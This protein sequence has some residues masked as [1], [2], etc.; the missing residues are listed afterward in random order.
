MAAVAIAVLSVAGTARVFCD[1]GRSE[2]PPGSRPSRPFSSSRSSAVS[3]RTRAF[4]GRPDHHLAAGWDGG[5]VRLFETRPSWPESRQIGPPSAGLASISSAGEVALILNCQLDWASVSARC[6]DANGRRRSTRSA[7]R[8]R[9]R[10]LDARRRELAAIQVAGGIIS[11]SSRSAG[12]STRRGQ[13]LT[14]WHSRLA[15]TGSPSSST[16]FISD[17]AGSLKIVDLEGRA[18]TVTSGWRTVR[19]MDWWRPATRS[20][21]RQAIGGDGP[22]C[23]AF[24]STARND[25]CFMRRLT[26][27][28]GPLPR[29]PRAP[30]DDRAPHA[31]DLVERRRHARLVMARL[32]DRGG[33]LGRRKD[34]AVLRVGRRRRR[35]PNVYVR[36]ADG[37]DACASEP[38]KRWRFHPT[39]AG[40]WRCRKPRRPG[41]WLMP[42]GAG[43]TAPSHGRTHGFLLGQIFRM[44][45]A[46]W[47]WHRTQSRSPLVHPGH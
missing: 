29:S 18:T 11:S 38:G 20:G 36:N 34:R 39:A 3:Y 7:G 12:R 46:Y 15:A 28:D 6:Q 31:H 13:A 40:R 5:Q 32:V 26:H 43:E 21:S 27:A 10:G 25:S 16:R 9:Q 45:A 24:R 42:T 4:A 35:A 23:T 17:E 47:W 30:G 44:D 2:R 8:R 41:S 1:P 14:G 33:S 37:S 22:A 19:G